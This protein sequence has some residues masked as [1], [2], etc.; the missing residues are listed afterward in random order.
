[1][2]AID[3]AG[4]VLTIDLAAIAANYRLLAGRVGRAACA[5]VVKAD[6]YGLGA[7]R[8]ATALA[9]AGCRH[10]FVAFADEGFAVRRALVD[11]GFEGGGAPD[12]FVLSGAPR[13]DEGCLLDAGL[14]PVLNSLGDVDA[15]SALAGRTRRRLPAALHVDTGMARLGLPENEVTALAAAPE[16]LDGVALRFILSHLACAD[17]PDHPLNG[18]QLE[19]FAAACRRLP[20]AP[21][22]LANSSGIFLGPAFHGDL[23]RPG[24]A[25]YGVAPR[26]GAANP[27]AQVVQLEGKIIQVR[28]IDRGRTIGYGATH[29]TERVTTVATIAV[30]YAD[31]Y[32][33]SLSNAGAAFVG[34]RRVP[35]VGRVSMDLITLDVTDVDAAVAC[36]GGRVELLGA[37]VTVDDVA[38]AAGTI[39]YEILTSL[40]GRYHRRHIGGD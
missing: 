16:R 5:A 18:A 23:A 26:P 25:L 21:T 1:M 17:L 40:G 13:G 15:W 9:R 28:Q 24:A 4:A 32:L 39:G 36:V 7:D 14:V 27:M 29:R 37:R 2:A 3:R 20:P 35:V 8:V 33:R 6:A 11:A 19:A 34:G 12:V 38:A 22:S 10:F 31:G 30:G